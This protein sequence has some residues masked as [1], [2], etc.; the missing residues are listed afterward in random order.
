M[1]GARKEQLGN[2]LR[3]KLVDIRH[4]ELEYYRKNCKL[5]GDLSALVAG[6]AYQG[7]R[8]HYY[9]E[10]QH[11]YRIH[12]NDTIEEVV[13]LSLLTFTIGVGL[14]VV[15]IAMLVAML[16]PSLALRGPDGSLHDAVEGMRGWNS[17]MLTL[18]MVSLVSL[19]I[20]ALSFTSGHANMGIKCR[21]ALAA[22]VLVGLGATLRYA[23]V[24]IEKF[25]LRSHQAV[26]GAFYGEYDKGGVVPAPKREEVVE[27]EDRE[28]AGEAGLPPDAFFWPLG[29]LFGRNF[30]MRGRK[31]YESVPSE[32]HR[33]SER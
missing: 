10:R 17:L 16:G 21:S 31:R 20:A 32:L 8:Y 28:F 11:S 1:L 5:L 23:G 14:Q 25:K 12:D 13:F 4:R 30:S 15:L 3:R 26:S 27:Q 22:T 9:L 18:F 7:I 2:A 24:V 29:A 6:F 19:Q 33:A